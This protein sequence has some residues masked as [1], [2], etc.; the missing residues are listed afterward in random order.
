LV[1][2]GT[3]LAGLTPIILLAGFWW[4][5]HRLA[6]AEARIHAIESARAGDPTPSGLSKDIGK[7]AERVK[8]VEAQIDSLA[9]QLGTTNN[10]LHALIEKGLSK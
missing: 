5:G 10:Y 3:A 6:N 7:V 2:I 1:E 8:G 9:D 4:L